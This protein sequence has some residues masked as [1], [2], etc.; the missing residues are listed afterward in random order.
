MRSSTTRCDV[1]VVNGGVH[2][3]WGGR[4]SILV[5]LLVQDSLQLVIAHVGLV[6]DDM[7]VGWTR[8]A[9]D[10]SV[11]AEVE[12]VLVGVSLAKVS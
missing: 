10:G 11:G 9:L 6:E 5:D 7:V 4:T 3:H 1:G 8:S 12:V 2:R